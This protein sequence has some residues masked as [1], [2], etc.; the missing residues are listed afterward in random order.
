[1]ADTAKAKKTAKPKQ[2][3]I[4]EPAKAAPAKDAV[5]RVQKSK[6]KNP[7]K[8][9]RLYVKSVFIGYKRSLRNQ[10]EHTSLLRIDGVSTRKDAE[11]YCGKRAAFVY[12]AKNKTTV[13]K[14]KG[15]YSKLRVIWGKVTRAHGNSGVVRAKFRRNLPAAAMGRRVRI[16]LYPSRV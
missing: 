16:M 11:W 14:R 3:K 2:V 8:P 15:V 12:K 13:P 10:R 4:T 5:K 6:P 1:M 9:G 7:A